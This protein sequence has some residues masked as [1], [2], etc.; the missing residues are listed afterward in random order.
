MI[1]LSFTKLCQNAP[2]FK[3]GMNGSLDIPRPWREGLGEGESG[4]DLHPHLNPPPSRGNL[5]KHLTQG[6]FGEVLVTA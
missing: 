6:C 1:R 5:Y 2:F 3:T 4:K